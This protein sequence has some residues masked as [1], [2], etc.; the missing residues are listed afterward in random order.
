MFGKWVLKVGP[1]HHVDFPDDVLRPLTK[2]DRPAYALGTEASADYIFDFG[3]HQKN[4]LTWVQTHS[5]FYIAWMV[6]ERVYDT[7]ENLKNAA[8]V[9]SQ[10]LFPVSL[11]NE[12][13]EKQ[14]CRRALEIRVTEGGSTGQS[15]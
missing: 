11:L 3:K 12:S 8:A 9:V 2:E 15:R 13:D 7:K 1:R 14:C 4:S 10:D 6:R 5:S